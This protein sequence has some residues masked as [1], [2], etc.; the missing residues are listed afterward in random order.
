MM[1]LRGIFIGVALTHVVLYSLIAEVKHFEFYVLIMLAM[2]VI[3]KA[4]EKS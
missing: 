2:L 1:V 3:M 4:L